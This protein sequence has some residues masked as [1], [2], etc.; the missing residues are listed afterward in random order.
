MNRVG[1]RYLLYKPSCTHTLL[2][3]WIILYLVKLASL[4]YKLYFIFAIIL[5]VWIMLLWLR[6]QKL[7]LVIGQR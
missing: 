5:L 4:V 3:P 1:D 7:A 2:L 6:I